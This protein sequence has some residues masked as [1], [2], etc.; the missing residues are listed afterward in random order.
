MRH[1]NDSVVMDFDLHLA[2]SVDC[3]FGIFVFGETNK[4]CSWFVS[5]EFM[6]SDLTKTCK[7]IF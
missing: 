7:Q 1:N 4:S 3:V 5:I 6:R 2:S